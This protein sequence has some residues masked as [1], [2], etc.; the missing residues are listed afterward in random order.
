MIDIVN[1][2][3]IDDMVLPKDIDAGRI[4]VIDRLL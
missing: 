3:L 1:K 4:K 2:D